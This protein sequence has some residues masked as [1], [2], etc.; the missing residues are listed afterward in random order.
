MKKKLLSILLTFCMVLTLLPTAAFAEGNTEEPPACT[1]E[2]ACTAENINADCPVCGAEGALPENCGKYVKPTDDVPT[3]PE[4]EPVVL[5]SEGETENVTWKDIG[6]GDTG[7]LQTSGYYKLTENIDGLN[8]LDIGPTSA[9][10]NIKLDLNGKTMTGTDSSLYTLWIN[11]NT[12]L[13]IIDSSTS[14][15]GSVVSPNGTAVYVGLGSTFTMEAGVIC[16]KSAGIVLESQTNP[17]TFTMNGGSVTG[18]IVV[19]GGNSK[20]E[21]NNGTVDGIW[22]SSH[23][24]LFA[25]GGTVTGPSFLEGAVL[26]KENTNGTVFNGVVVNATGSEI[27]GKLNGGTVTGSGS[28]DSPFLI[29]NAAGLKWFRDKVNSATE[30]DNYYLLA[31][32]KLMND[33]V[34][35][36]SEAWTPIAPNTISIGGT[37]YGYCGTFDGNGHTISGLNVNG[38]FQCAGLFGVV[39]GGTIKNLTVAGSVAS[40][41][42]TTP[43][44]AGGIVGKAKNSTIEACA[45]LS[46]VSA[47]QYV[48]GIAGQIMGTIVRDCYNVGT[49]TGDGT[50]GGIVGK[51]FQAP[52]ESHNMIANCYN[53]GNVGNVGN[54]SSSCVGGILGDDGTDSVSNCYYLKGTAEKAIVFGAPDDIR[55]RAPMTAAQFADGTVLKLLINGREDSPW[56]SACKYLDAA[57]MTLPVFKGQGDAHTHTWGA[58]TSNGDG[59]RTRT[60]DCGASETVNYS[61]SSSRNYYT[62]QATAGTGGAIS[63]S[64]KVSVREGRN[65]V[66]TITP[67]QGYVVSNVQIDGESVGAV[68]SYTFENVRKA[69]T[70]AVSFAKAKAF[71]DVPAGSYYEDAV[72]WAVENG[73]T[74]GTDDTHFSPDDVCTRAQMVTFLWRAAGSPK[75]ENGKNPFTDVKADAYYYDA[76]LWAV[77][78]GVTSGTSA[79]TFSPDATVTRGQTVTFLY[80]NAGSPEVSGTMPF[81]DVETDAYYAKAVQW[82]VQQKITT[83]TSETTFSPMSDCTR[84]QIVTFL[85][86]AK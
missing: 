84:G 1:C 20:M 30:T 26:Q 37:D 69:H 45:N 42:A 71:V 13:T 53:V 50:A 51:T 2:M 29:S 80:R 65:Q 6:Q 52:H 33:I 46:S 82:A 17:T 64:G 15:G 40:S 57:K 23:S 21:L 10:A 38:S 7:K 59:T 44:G 60:C 81:T 74:Q 73:I 48:G 76:V 12:T 32:A 27:P 22:L 11:Q 14:G 5:N 24:T 36:S 58:W 67:D 41:S 61:N 55:V 9:G 31:C 79:T 70:I 54:V 86:R 75:V 43:S 78:K 56:D 47:K 72:N 35:D 28:S 77:E 49:V 18:G 25:N 39:T 19:D 68:T 4:S 66:F 63:P 34:L 3:Q 85:Y 83:G 8:G 16:G 62:I